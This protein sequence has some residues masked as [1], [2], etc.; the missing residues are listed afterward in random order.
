MKDEHKTKRQPIDKEISVMRE[1]KR[2]LGI[3]IIADAPWGTHL[4]QFYQ[5]NEEYLRN[6]MRK[7]R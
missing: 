7:K 1:D 2:K 6:R 4:C 3:D 5:T